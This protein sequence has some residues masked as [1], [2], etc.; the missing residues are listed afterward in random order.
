MISDNVTDVE[1]GKNAGCKE[2]YLIATNE[3][4]TLF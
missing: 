2:S 1:S 3:D 4:N